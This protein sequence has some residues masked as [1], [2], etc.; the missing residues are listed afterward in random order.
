MLRDGSRRLVS[1]ITFLLARNGIPRDRWSSA[2]GRDLSGSVCWGGHL[3]EVDAAIL[4]APLAFYML[5]KVL[6]ANDST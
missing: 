3:D 1:S 2:L 4:A 5:H 6:L